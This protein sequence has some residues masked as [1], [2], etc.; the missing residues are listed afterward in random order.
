LSLA[1]IQGAGGAS[2]LPEILISGGSPARTPR[3]Q[4]EAKRVCE[5]C[6]V[7]HQCLTYA[8]WSGQ[9]SG[10]WGGKDERELDRLRR[11]RRAAQRA[12]ERGTVARG[13]PR[14]G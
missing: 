3:H 6:P 7:A 11:R 9:T 2:V 1:A 14:A 13:V 4:E 8:L 10:V 5:R 12:A